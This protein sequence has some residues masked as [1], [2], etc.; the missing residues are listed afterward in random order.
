MNQ[1]LSPH[2][3]NKKDYTMISL[4]IPNYLKTN[5]DTICKFKRFNRTSMI[6]RLMESFLRYENK[7]MKEDTSF[8]KMILD[9]NKN[10]SK[11]EPIVEPPMIPLS[12]DDIDWEDRLGKLG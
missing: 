12:S 1:T 3:S 7:Q 5:F 2:F 6:V 8:N 9:L 10:Y 11:S 4:N